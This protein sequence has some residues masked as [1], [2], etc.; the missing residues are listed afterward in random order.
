M[1]QEPKS[2]PL[3]KCKTEK[4]A[5]MF[6]LFQESPRKGLKSRQILSERRMDGEKDA[7]RALEEREWRCRRRERVEKTGRSS[8]NESTSVI[9]AHH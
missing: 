6:L 5:E 8:R 9:I 2:A 3:S 7:T 4:V 1:S